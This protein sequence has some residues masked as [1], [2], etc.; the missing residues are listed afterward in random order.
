MEFSYFTRKKD[1]EGLGKESFDVLI[2]GGGIAGSGITSVLTANNLKVLLIDKGD[3]ASGTSSNSSKLIH[4]GLRYLAQGHLILTRE[5]LKERNYLLK[6]SELVK[7]MEFDILI[8]NF[9]WSKFSLYFGIFLYNL[10]GGRF[11]V[12]KFK[13]GKYSYPGSIGHFS[14]TDAVTDDALL[15]VYNVV[16]SVM[17]GGVAINYL[18]ATHFEDKGDYV[19]TTLKDRYESGEYLIKSRIVV[20]A[21]GPWVNDMYDKYSGK[22][23]ENFKLSKGVHLIFRGDKVNLRNAVAFKSHIDGRQM[24]AIPRDEV[25]LAG[26]TDDF[27]E[28]PDEITIKEEERK[29]ILSSVSRI[30]G[31]LGERDIIGEYS[32]IRPLYGE[33]SNPGTVTRDF[34][35]KVTGKMLSVMGVKITNYRNASRKIAKHIGKMLNRSLNTTGLPKILYRRE[36]GDA[37]NL[38]ITRECALKKEDVIRRR[39]GYYYFKKDG[40]RLHESLVE[41]KLQDFMKQT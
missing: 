1:L 14:Y 20:N 29:Y 10:L 27:I 12:P 18:E 41:Q 31:G 36:K 30:F 23:I 22:R 21:S 34:D 9:S 26:T 2:V 35:L 28:S 4:G 40:G 8:D 6:N 13:T 39:L 38:A 15:V 37:L 16:T 5:L 7:E 32:G 25:I 3:F 33:G 17:M 24:F 19:E 11:K